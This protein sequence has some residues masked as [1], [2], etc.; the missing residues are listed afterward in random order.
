MCW[1]SISGVTSRGRSRDSTSAVSDSEGEQPVVPGTQAPGQ[2]ATG[3]PWHAPRPETRTV[4]DVRTLR[5]LSHPIRIAL[6]EIVSIY[7]PI[8]AT[9]AGE[10]I[11]ET[12]T[13]CSYHLRELAKVGIVEDAGGGASRRRPWRLATTSLRT[14]KVQDDPA[15]A[16]AVTAFAKVGRDRRMERYQTWVETEHLYPEAWRKAIRESEHLGWLTA[17]E[18]AE[19]NRQLGELLSA[20]LDERR[21]PPNRSQGAVPVQ[22]L[23]MSHPLALPDD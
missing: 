15:V 21:D 19:L 11:G 9:E 17:D 2:A 12:P 10:R 16:L 18:L 7:G 23:L 20:Y 1:S 4:D 8:T 22:V 5:A 6:A 13:T 14:S 3:R